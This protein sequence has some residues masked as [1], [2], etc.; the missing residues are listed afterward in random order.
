MES[1]LDQWGATPQDTPKKSIILNDQHAHYLHEKS[2]GRQL[3]KLYDEQIERFL[4]EERVKE[5]NHKK[6]VRDTYVR[7]GGE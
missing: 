3:D 5:S 6:Y 4:E 7:I 2:F 1:T